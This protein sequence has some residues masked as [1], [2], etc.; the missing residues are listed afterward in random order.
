MR[1]LTLILNGNSNNFTTSFYPR[2]HLE[3][4]IKYEAALLSIDM[5]NS[6]PNITNENND[7]T[8]STDCGK[9]YQTIKLDTGCYELQAINDE[10]SRQMIVNDDYNKETNES[11]IN[12]TANLSK[13]KSVIEISHKDYMIDF[14][15]ENS[16]G[17]TLGFNKD[18]VIFGYHESQNIVDIMKI[19]S[20]LLAIDII[21]GGYLNG[22]QHPIIYSFFPDVGPGR[23][24]IERPNPSLSYH[25]V[26]R[27]SI[28]RITVKIIDQN[29]TPIDIRGET[30]TIKL[31]IREV[32]DMKETIKR[33]IKELKIENIL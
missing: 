28:D 22:V 25:P 17:S 29:Y 23:K 5:Y 32:I 24:I 19:N 7:F 21:S 26:N 30:V 6:I 13:Q 1:G 12:I 18:L 14:N 2:I 16:I 3:R 10:I 27:L 8:Y 15:K 33:A 11:Y 9:T 20:I 4:E 31:V